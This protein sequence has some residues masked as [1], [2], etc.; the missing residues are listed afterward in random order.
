MST[1]KQHSTE[2]DVLL[3]ALAERRNFARFT[4]NGLTDEQ[5]RATPTASALSIGGL[6]KHLA[7]TESEWATFVRDGVSAFDG[8][9][10]AGVDLADPS[11]LPPGFD[12]AQK[13]EFT[14]LA[15]ETLAQA[16]ADY[17]RVAA[18]TEEIVRALPT[19][20]VDHELPPA[21]WFEPGARWSARNVLLHLIG[22]TA[23]HSGHADIIRES[24]DG[25]KTMG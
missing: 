6:I 11:S 12:E 16:L 24:L 3:A 25:Q 8:A 20:D 22:E 1:T 23:Q 15:D 19:L 10:W 18:R 21:P 14:L 2:T 13:A 4:T 17:E 5:A 7:A 9:S